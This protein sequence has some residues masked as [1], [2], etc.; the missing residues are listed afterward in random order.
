MATLDFYF[1]LRHSWTCA[2]SP[3][4]KNLRHPALATCVSNCHCRTVTP[5]R[6]SSGRFRPRVVLFAYNRTRISS[7]FFLHI[8][9]F[10]PRVAHC[11]CVSETEE[12]TWEMGDDLVVE[13]IDVAPIAEEVRQFCH[14]LKRNRLVPHVR[15]QSLFYYHFHLC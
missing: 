14:R 9:P 1:W 6:V 3:E 10:L 11:C 12:L 13:Y 4:S 5:C 7:I 8:L 15:R 2:R